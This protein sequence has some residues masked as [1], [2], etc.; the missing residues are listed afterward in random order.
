MTNEEI[1]GEFMEEEKEA[2]IDAI[3]NYAKK[4]YQEG[5]FFIATFGTFTLDDDLIVGYGTK[6]V[7]KDCLDDM[8]ERLKKEKEGD[9]VIW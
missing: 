7:L 3:E 5:V 2:L 4:H 1:K 8:Q 6:E 9:F